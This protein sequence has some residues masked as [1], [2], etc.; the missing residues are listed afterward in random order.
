MHPLQSEI[1]KKLLVQPTLIRKWNL[2]K[3]WTC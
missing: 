2:E 1:I 3:A